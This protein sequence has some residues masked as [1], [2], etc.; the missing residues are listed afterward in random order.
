[1]ESFPPAKRG[2][3]MAA[4]VVGVV[5]APVL[6]PVIG[7]WLTDNYSWRWIFTSTSRAAWSPYG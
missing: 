5:V 7:G 4:Y 1:M 6:G 3:A 2:A